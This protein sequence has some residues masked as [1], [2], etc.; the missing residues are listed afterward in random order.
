MAIDR[1]DAC[2][3][4][5]AELGRLGLTAEAGAPFA[6]VCFGC[7]HREQQR[8]RRITNPNRVPPEVAF[9]TPEVNRLPVWRRRHLKRLRRLND[10]DLETGEANTYLPPRAKPQA[11]RLAVTDVVTTMHRANL[12]ASLEVIADRTCTLAWLRSFS[13]HRRRVR[14]ALHT[15]E[16]W[17]YVSRKGPLWIAGPM[18]Q[19]EEALNPAGWDA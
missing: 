3:R 1:C 15:L 6:R 17:G 5:R 4:D 11:I 7:F 14:A 18:V 8:Q 9:G 10:W 13:E 2:R 12:P 16:R 19:I